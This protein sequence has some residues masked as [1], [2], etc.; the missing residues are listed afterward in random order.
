MPDVVLLDIEVPGRP[1]PQGSVKAY[2]SRVIQS[3]RVLQHRQLLQ[4]AIAQEW[5]SRDL[6][7]GPVRLECIFRFLRPRNHY[8]TGRNA[9][10]LKPGAPEH[11][12]SM[13]DLDK[14]LRAVFD[15]LTGVVLIDDRQVSQTKALKR[16]AD[17]DATLLRII[18]LGEEA[19]G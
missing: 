3:P 6:H 18:A 9:D 12:D 7:P 4:Y 13:P 19:G 14:T 17:R 16:W 8:G 1:V 11:M 10:V 15:A 2:Q 5:G